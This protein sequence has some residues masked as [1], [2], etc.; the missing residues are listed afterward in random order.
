[1]TIIEFRLGSS[2]R[3]KRRH[4]LETCIVQ[5]MIFSFRKFTGQRMKFVQKGISVVGWIGDQQGLGRF[6]T[7]IQNNQE[8]N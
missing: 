8:G 1:M 4:L 5:R 3:K 6:V 2:T 7:L